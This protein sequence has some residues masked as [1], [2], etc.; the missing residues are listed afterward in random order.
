M[1][2]QKILLIIALVGVIALIIAA[3]VLIIA[4]SGKKKNK[5]SDKGKSSKKDKRNGK[6]ESKKE[7]NKGLLPEEEMI[8]YLSTGRKSTRDIC[9]ADGID[10]SQLSYIVVNDGGRDCYMTALY[11]DK[12]PNRSSFA[13]TYSEI[14]NFPNCTTNVFIE[15]FNQ[16]ESQKM[17][18]KRVIALE[19]ELIA[20][21]KAG[22]TNRYRKIKAKMNECEE[23]AHVIEAGLNAFFKVGFL[24]NLRAQ[25]LEEL[26]EACARFYSYGSEKNIDIVGCYGAQAEALLAGAPLNKMMKVGKGP[27]KDSIIKYHVMDKNSLGDTF[28]HTESFFSHRYGILAGRNMYTQQPVLLDPYDKSHSGYNICISGI[29]GVGKS[30]GMKMWISRWM[31]VFD[32]RFAAVDYDSPNGSEGEYVQL[33]RKEGGVVF[34]LKHNSEN[35]LNIF[36]IDTELE[37][38]PSM[39][40]EI[41]TLNLMEKCAD[42]TNI[43]LSMIKEGREVTDFNTDVYLSKIVSETVFE[44]YDA[45]GIKEGQPETIY[46]Q[47]Q[48]LVDGRIVAGKVRKRMPT[49]HDFFILL[50]NKR[51]FNTD[52]LQDG[53]YSIAIAG[54]QKYVKECYYSEKSIGEYDAAGYEKLPIDENGLKYTVIDG[55][56]ERVY[57]VRGVKPYFDGQST[58]HINSE[59]QC[60]DIDISPLPKQDRDI[61]QQVACNYINEYFIKKNSSN[62]NKLKKCIVLIDEFHNTFGY[63]E[64]REFI[65]SMY[66][67]AR[68]RFVC[69]AT[70]TQALA[71]YNQYEET[72]AIVKNSCMKILYKQAKMDAQFI[73]EVTPLTP[74]QIDAVM[75]LGGTVDANGE[76][77]KS[78]KGE[79]CIVDNEDTVAFVKVD[80][81]RSEAA[82]CETDPEKI[83]RMMGVKT[84]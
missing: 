13:K 78:R 45:L 32:Y 48:T 22:D 17:L 8:D 12:L 33:V 70:I 11:I 5:Q 53:A 73:S 14:M 26:N 55:E 36:D 69:M 65:A 76:I 28:N 29:T 38:I 83:A 72:K 31:E 34:Q 71:D 43:I 56:R 47:G 41:E 20:A 4:M 60:M 50:L 2:T 16:A 42:R 44:L 67:Q 75:Q 30:A 21:E 7:N 19:S 61:A 64:I 10:T 27:F 58:M 1:L 9:A 23:W 57:A 24:F 79:C 6:N 35:V 15:P 82:I 39:K 3:C 37:Y 46:E 63:K 68:K 18:D 59:V 80:Y 51:R 84:A 81:L 25:S 74:S 52:T 77:D 66:R 62:P 49:L 40:T 54:I